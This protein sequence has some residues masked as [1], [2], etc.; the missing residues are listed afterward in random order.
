MP[1]TIVQAT[2]L[3]SIRVEVVLGEGRAITIPASLLLAADRVLRMALVREEDFSLE[4]I[5]EQEDG[6]T[7]WYALLGNVDAEGSTPWEAVREL[8]KKLEGDS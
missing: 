4:P 5:D 7:V 3:D 1:G 8:A 2:N 6:R